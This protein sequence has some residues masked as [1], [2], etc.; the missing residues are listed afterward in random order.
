MIF[1][2]LFLTSPILL[3]LPSPSLDKESLTR[4]GND[5]PTG[6]GYFKGLEDLSSEYD[7]LG[8]VICGVSPSI[9]EG[10]GLY[11]MPAL[12]IYN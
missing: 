9:C 7:M 5:F 1:L 12:E 8:F 2:W 4:Y 10:M 11:I 3:P 6:S